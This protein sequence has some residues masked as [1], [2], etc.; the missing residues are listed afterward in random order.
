MWVVLA[1]RRKD[2][3]HWSPG[4]YDLRQLHRSNVAA[5]RR[6]E[7]RSEREKDELILKNKHISWSSPDVSSIGY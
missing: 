1:L 7:H 6:R 4:G 3:S 5:C 2:A